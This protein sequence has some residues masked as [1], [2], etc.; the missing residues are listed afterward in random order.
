ML[1]TFPYPCLGYF[2]MGMKRIKLV[3]VKNIDK[4]WGG[5]LFYVSIFVLNYG[6]LVV[7]VNPCGCKSAAIAMF[8]RL[9]VCEM[10]KTDLFE[11]RL[12]ISTRLLMINPCP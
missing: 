2:W 12:S 8:L 3:M 5:G 6:I 4:Y 7:P 1:E 10:W 11:R 9:P